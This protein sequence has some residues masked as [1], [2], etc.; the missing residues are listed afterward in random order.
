MPG[1]HGHS[2]APG[3]CVPATYSAAS[4]GG[5]AKPAQRNLWF[6]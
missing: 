6:S 1:R 2:T 3:I 5:I 4:S